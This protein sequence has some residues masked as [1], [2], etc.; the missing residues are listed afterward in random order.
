MDSENNNEK[1]NKPLYPS[2]EPS[3]SCIDD[4]GFFKDFENEFPAIV[5]N[6]SLTSKLDFLTKPTLCPQHIDKFDLKDETSL[7]EY[8]EVEQS[9]LYV[10]FGIPF[11]PKRY[12]K[13]GDCARKLRRL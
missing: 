5:Y 1:V 10:S 6:D 7:S 13:D 2:P 9:N 12:Y 3:V 4:L 11:E 8:D